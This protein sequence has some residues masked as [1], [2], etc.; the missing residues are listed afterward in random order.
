MLWPN[1]LRPVP[2]CTIMRFDPQLHA[3]S[4]RQTVERYTEFKSR[5]LGEASRQT[6]CRFRACRA[7]DI[8]PVS[9]AEAHA[10]HSREVSSVTVDLALHTDQPLNGLGL[11][12]LRFYRSEE[13]RVE[14]EC[15]SRWAQ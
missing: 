8:F 15:R 6:Q 12:S 7:V 2:S 9:V 3:I 14:K 5:P 10:E 1:C 4:E 13:R 11:D